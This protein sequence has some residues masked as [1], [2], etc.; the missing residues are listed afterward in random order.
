MGYDVTTPNECLLCGA[1]SK[2]K[3]SKC[4]IDRIYKTRVCCVCG[5]EWANIEIRK[6][7]YDAMLKSYKLLLS[8]R[9]AVER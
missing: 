8:I 6:S 4:R 3:S 1:G 9:E 7:D 2:V 5:H